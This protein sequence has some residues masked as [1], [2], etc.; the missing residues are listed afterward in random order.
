LLINKNGDRSSSGLPG[1]TFTPGSLGGFNDLG[2]MAYQVGFAGPGVTTSNNVGIALR[3]YDA[4][5]IVARLGD[6]APGTEPGTVFTSIL[7]TPTLNNADQLVFA[8][9]LNSD[10]NNDT[11]LWL[12]APGDLRLVFRKGDPAPG[13]PDG[14]TFAHWFQLSPPIN[15]LGQVAFLTVLQ[16]PG[17]TSANDL[18]IWATDR[19]GNLQL[20]AREG[21][22]IEVAPNDYRVIRQLNLRE[23]GSDRFDHPKL[24]NRGQIAFHASFLDNSHGIFISNAVAV[25]EPANLCFVA[26]IAVYLGSICRQ[27]AR[28]R[29]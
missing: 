12:G 9:S 19:A 29:R 2:H 18:G 27:R 4:P 6:A 1:E 3:R 5:L 14:V 21:D 13:V 28:H 24:N 10:P 22:A 16:G 11:G 15:D 7:T 20:I 25:P 8:A 26:T 17:V 23:S